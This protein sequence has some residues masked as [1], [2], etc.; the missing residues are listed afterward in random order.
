LK[1]ILEYV[2]QNAAIAQGLQNQGTAILSD[3]VL[4]CGKDDRF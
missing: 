1:R 3:R 4:A 2:L